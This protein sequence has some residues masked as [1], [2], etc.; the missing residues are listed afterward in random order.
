MDEVKPNLPNQ[1]TREKMCTQKYSKSLK[2]FD[3]PKVQLMDGQKLAIH[4]E[5]S[6]E[7]SN[8]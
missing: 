3:K 6:K 5:K 4:P 1:W 7:L 8:L 2:E